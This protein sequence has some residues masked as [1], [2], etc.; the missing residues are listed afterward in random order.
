MISP[1]TELDAPRDAVRRF[2]VRPPL[3][4]L[5]VALGAALLHM[6]PW[7]HAQA[8]TPAG[9]TF[10]GN[11]TVSPDAMQ[12]RVWMRQA[13]EHGLLVDD[14]FTAE[15]SRPFLPVAYYWAVAHLAH[16]TGLSPEWANAWVGAPVAAV[17][18]LLVYLTARYFLVDRRMSWWVFLAVLFGGGLSA[19]LRLLQKV[20][21][22]QSLPVVSGLI[23]ASFRSDA[24]SFEDSRF[25]YVIR[26]L[27]DSH[28][29]LIWLWT[30]A[31]VLS[32]YFA[33]RRPAAWRSVFTALL[34]AGLTLLHVYEGVTLL[35][36][37]A[38]VTLLVWRKGLAPGP[39]LV[40][41][42][43][44]GLAV[45][46]CFAWLY[47]LQRS[48]GL[49]FPTWKAPSFP[50]ANIVLAF[51]LAWGLIAVGLA[52]YWRQAGL[53]ACFLLGWALGCTLLLLAHPYY[54]YHDRGA[55]TLQIVL[56]VIA[57]AIWIQRYG[58]LTRRALLV[59]LLVLGAAPL[60][61]THFLWGATR[62]DA[63]KP[64]LF[65]TPEDRELV[66]LLARRAG[67]DDVLL[68]PDRDYRWLYPE[69]PGRSWDAHFFLTVDFERKQEEKRRFFEDP[70]GGQAA[71]LERE[72]IRFLYVDAARDPERFAA[73][74]GLAPLL[75]GP[76]GSLFEVESA[77]RE[78]PR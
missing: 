42:G 24:P 65:Q 32:L 40:N 11:V 9:W 64:W 75:Q 59:A 30:L 36:I 25:H 77:P 46:A 68:A 67:E 22:A 2:W 14:R 37:A 53:E 6:L 38:G 33:L 3:W 26:T 62:F 51:P 31:A 58:T 49:P 18:A 57:G 50:L 56:H 27:F 17:F 15:A 28:F 47:S 60:Y 71:F 7:W 55:V 61:V 63:A 19:H 29:L 74:P 35:A 52:G 4:V 23:E 39:A 72:G 12:Y 8:V 73:L 34:F 41:L 43:L 45:G 69:Y 44:C 16:S 13:L 48:C 78:R 70:P 76:R 5:L 10:T 66:A 54:P 20:P 1:G 21:G